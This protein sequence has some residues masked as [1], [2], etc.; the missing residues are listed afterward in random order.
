MGKKYKS[1]EKVRVI[2][3]MKEAPAIETASKEGKLFKQ[4]SKK[5]ETTIKVR[6]S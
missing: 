4:L 2:V 6:K 5:Y 1:N 3:E